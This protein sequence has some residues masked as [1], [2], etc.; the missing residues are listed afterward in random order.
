MHMLLSVTL[1]HDVHLAAGT[2]TSCRE[3]LEH[4]T[5]ASTLFNDVLSQPIPP[6]YRDAV[7]ATGIFLGAASFWSIGST[8]P[9]AVW[10]LKI[11][12]PDDLAWLRIGEG[13]KHLWRVAQPT[14]DDSIF[15]KIV[16]GYSC[17]NVPQWTADEVA[18][19]PGPHIAAH[20][21]KTLGLTGILDD[22]ANVYHLPILALSRCPN[23]KVTEEN[24]LKF[25]YVMAVITE[26]FLKLLEVKDIKAVFI[27]GWWYILLT[28]GDMWWMSRRARVEGQAIRIWLRR[29][30]GGEELADLL[31]EIE[32]HS[33]GAEVAGKWFFEARGLMLAEYEKV[34]C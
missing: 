22:P 34:S 21:V 11:P 10:P 16:K 7:W 1:M 28:K 27:M 23:A 2:I 3:A 19:G 33:W 9:Y 18:S 25:L 8:D 5:T 31:D 24:A 26:P 13:K 6:S 14:R 20:V 12:E 15:C 17:L 29:Q 30:C 32:R 4:W